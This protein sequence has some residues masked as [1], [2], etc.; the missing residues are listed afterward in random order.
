[1]NASYLPI[2]E[3]LRRCHPGSW[4][5]CE[6]LA[7]LRC[8]ELNRLRRDQYELKRGEI[9][10]AITRRYQA[11][12]AIQRMMR[13]RPIPRHRALVPIAQVIA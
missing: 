3:T 7:H 11:G 4:R 12:E 1:M 10:T 2:P 5:G 9:D 8:G 13:E 6:S